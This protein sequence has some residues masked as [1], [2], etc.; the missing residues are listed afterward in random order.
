M[1]KILIALALVALVISSVSLLS[2]PNVKADPSEAQILSYSWYVAP[3]TTTLA[4]YIGDLIVV[5]E[6]QNVGTNTLSNVV[7]GAEAYNATGD[8]VGSAEFTAYVNYLSPGQKAPFY[9]DFAPDITTDIS[10]FDQNWATYV[11]NVTV[12]VLTASDSNQTQYSGLTVPSGSVSVLNT[13]DPYTITGTV[14]NTGNQATGPVWVISTFYNASGT[15]VALN[16]T[17]YISQSLS[18]GESAPFTATPVD[19]TPQL[20][21]S[22]TSYSIL[23][24]SDPAPSATPTP[25][26]ITTP[27]QTTSPTSSNQPTSSASPFGIS[28]S[29]TIYLAAAA[30]AIVLVIL[31][32]LM[33]LRRRQR[34][35]EFDL[36]PPPPPI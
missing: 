6:V 10:T 33:L 8:L 3:T 20:S 18:P 16:F 32:V 23:I 21:S 31:V 26:P 4:Q 17:D 14:Q 2:A 25:T 1:K 35:A 7:V 15:V 27:I 29:L 5:G 24:Q 13:T 30:V 28:A 11:T 22:I 19:D 36:P 12:Q 34:N 9:L